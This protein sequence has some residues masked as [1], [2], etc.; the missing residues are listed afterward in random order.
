VQ[1]LP[2]ALLLA[3][4]LA[5]CWACGEKPGVPPTVVT[6]PAPAPVPPPP[7]PTP[8]P[9]P[10]PQEPAALDSLTLTPTSIPSQ[11]TSEGRVTLTRE[12]PAGGVVV[13]LESSVVDVA[14]TPR[15]VTVPEG[16][17]TATFVITAPTIGRTM[18]TEI[19]ATYLGV[20]RR[21]TLTV[22][23]PL[24]EAEF[25]FGIGNVQNRCYITDASG[26]LH[27][28]F[29]ASASRG[30]P[31]LYHWTL[32]HMDR[33]IKVTTNHAVIAAPTTCDFLSGARLSQFSEFTIQVTLQVEG[34]GGIKSGNAIKTA[35]IMPFGT[36]THGYCG[37]F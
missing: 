25:T 35:I 19:F 7:A 4:C 2:R 31:D 6:P 20:T 3:V 14:R 5:A 34:Q 37:Y 11:G 8:A 33:E 13:A 10:P 15:N 21:A 24:L 30:F 16:S 17:T 26:H 32:R 28:P 1:S 27:C 22:G 18:T 23:P 29:D 36:G 9:T 12:A